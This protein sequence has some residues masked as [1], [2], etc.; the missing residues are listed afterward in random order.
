MP[1]GKRIVNN[2]KRKTTKTK[3]CKRMTKFTGY[4]INDILNENYEG[5]DKKKN[6]FDENSNYEIL[7]KKDKKRKIRR[8]AKTALTIAGGLTAAHLG[9]KFYDKNKDHLKFIADRGKAM[10]DENKETYNT[11]IA[12]YLDPLWNKIV[13]TAQN[14]MNSN[15]I[16]GYRNYYQD[17]INDKLEDIQGQLSNNPFKV[18]IEDLKSIIQNMESQV[19]GRDEFKVN[20]LK[21]TIKDIITGCDGYEDLTKLFKDGQQTGALGINSLNNMI[22]TAREQYNKIMH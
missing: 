2:N 4:S 18:N 1:R 9:K 7:V 19:K 11:K 5:D 13:N 12:P 17:G 20:E 16:R 15:F 8:A 22:W 3:R 14:V 6:D 10:Y 21:K